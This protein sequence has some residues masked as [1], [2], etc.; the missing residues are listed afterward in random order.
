MTLISLRSDYS[1]FVV[2]AGGIGGVSHGPL[3]LGMSQV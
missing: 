1:D 3:G 2:G